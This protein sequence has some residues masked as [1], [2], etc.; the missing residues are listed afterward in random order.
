MSGPARADSPTSPTTTKNAQKQ[1]TKRAKKAPEQR[2]AATSPATAT[3][4][5]S[6]ASED[7][8][9]TRIAPLAQM[10]EIPQTP[11]TPEV[12]EVPET[13]EV[14]EMP[15]MPDAPPEAP[16]IPSV[17]E[18]PA[19]PEIPETPETPETPEVPE[20][21]E[22]PEPER[23]AEPPQPPEPITPTEPTEPTE[24]EEPPVRIE[25]T[26]PGEPGEPDNFAVQAPG[27]QHEHTDSP[28]AEVA[29]MDVAAVTESPAVPADVP[30][31]PVAT[32]A[33]KAAK[34][35][36]AAVRHMP[37]LATI[38]RSRR[39]GAAAD[40]TV[41][42]TRT[43]AQEQDAKSAVTRPVAARYSNRRR[44]AIRPPNFVWEN[45]P[46]LPYLPWPMRRRVSASARPHPLPA[47]D[48]V[49]PVAVV[50]IFAMAL[51]GLMG[52]LQ[53]LGVANMLGGWLLVGALIA[54]LG[55]VLAYIFHEIESLQRYAPIALM[56]SQ[57][58]LLV[59]ALL[60]VG[61]RASLLVLVPALI[62]AAALM[63]DTL[64]AS[65][66]ALGALL[67]YAL[68]AGFS[69]SLTVTPVSPPTGAAALVFDVLCV[70]V[71]LLAALWLL[72]AILSGRE[73]AQA[74]ARA[75]R[76]EADVLRNL[77][78]QF[79]QEV[80]DD[81][82]KLESA[83]LQALKGQDVGAMPT[84]GMYRLLA[85]TILDTATRLEVLQRDRE[86]RLRLEGALRVVVRAVER[87][88]L[89][90]EPEWPEH[91][92]TAIDELVALLRSPRLEAAYQHEAG[93]P[94]ITP[95]LIPIPT[96]TVERDT[97]PP[98][99][100]SR[101]LSGASWMASRRRSRPRRPDLYP[102]PPNAGDAAH[103]GHDEN[104]PTGNGH[105]NWPTHDE[106]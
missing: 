65:V 54:G 87:Q 69:I 20:I 24:P 71:G 82:S 38:N 51:L 30:V 53:G 2:M 104:T 44:K 14:P 16:E 61:P 56:V 41:S 26:E 31:V 59:W 4:A 45:D 76:H 68:F 67:I 77:V 57:L 93:A 46:R 5:Q 63:S 75:R 11:Q 101:P 72:L 28:A 55:G 36:E 13:P 1:N 70:V 48:A 42:A 19:G 34:A 94:S 106:R 50:Q 60:I 105:T 22:T 17:P 78:T 95:R 47:A 7:V 32:E 92:G 39:D 12:P 35:A 102:L 97:P 10:P 83:L 43:A 23:P 15:E 58:G 64:L 100:V 89:G 88:W 86:E 99:P 29:E 52:A 80:Q 6:S 96:L 62:E 85:E 98:T 84:E 25:P 40:K 18:T 103:D 37:T 73:R 33:A 21:P 90:I 49:T 91:T 66:F 9:L 3:P 74:I 8:T 27:I 79:R 81:T